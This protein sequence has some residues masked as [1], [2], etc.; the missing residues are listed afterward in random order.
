MTFKSCGK[1]QD[2]ESIER[3][4][5]LDADEL[6]LDEDDEEENRLEDEVATVEELLWTE[7]EVVWLELELELET[8]VE[9]PEDEIVVEVVAVL[10][11]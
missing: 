10:E 2:H 7:P 8:C 3:V 4:S 6:L 1:G 5:S 9:L 11:V